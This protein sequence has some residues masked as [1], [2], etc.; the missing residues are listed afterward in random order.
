MPNRLARSPGRNC[1]AGGSTRV[2]A[3]RPQRRQ[4][5]GRRTWGR[6]RSARPGRASRG[7]ASTRSRSR[8]ASVRAGSGVD[9][10]EQGRARDEHR[11]QAAA[12]PAHPEERHRD[13]EALAPPDARRA[14]SPAS[15]ARSAF[16]VG[17]DHALGR[18]AAARREHDREV[19]GRSHRRFERGRRGSGGARRG[20]ELAGHRHVAQRRGA[21]R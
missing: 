10:G 14:S 3:A 16:A 1:S 12:E 9:L 7:T 11:E 19:V 21:R 15:V 5:G 8:N 4:V 20:I 2:E 13:V 18:A 17:V 6:P